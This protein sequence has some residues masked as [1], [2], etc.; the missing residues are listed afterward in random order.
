MPAQATTTIDGNQAAARVAYLCSELAAIYPITPSSPMGE[1]ADQWSNERQPNAWGT[2]PHV[3]EMQSEAGAA[4]AVH[5]ALQRGTLAT[6]FTASQGLLLMI[7]N[8][9]KIAGELT[10]TVFHVA[11]RTVATHALSIFC[12]H[13][14]VMATRATGFALLSS[15]SVQ[16]AMDLALV[17]H[18][19]TL[20][21][22]IPFLHFFDGFR[23]SHE[24]ATIEPVSAEDVRA[25]IDTELL[26]RHRE[27]ALSPDRPFIRGT[28]QN[29]DV[30]FQARESSNPYYDDCP[31]L[32]EEAMRRFADQ[33]GRQY[34]LFEYGGAPDA[35]RVIVIMG[36]AAQ[37]ATETARYLN[38]QGEKVGVV[39]VHLYRPFSIAHF[40]AV[41]PATTKT[42]AV[43]DRTKEPGAAGEPL[44]ADVV[45]AVH[46]GR[47]AGLVH[48]QP[49]IVGGRYGL[50]SKEFTPGMVKGIYDAMRN[51]HP[52]N[53]FTV[54]IVDDLTGSSIAYPGDLSIEPSPGT[55]AVFYGLGSDGTVSANKNSIMIIG[56]H[57]DNYAQGYFVYD[58]RKA[59]SVTVSHL[60]FGPTP[61]SAPYLIRQADFVGCHQFAF[62][63]RFDVLQHAR[64]GAMVLIDCPYPPEQVWEHLPR[65]VQ[66][67]I[68]K[69]RLRLY[70]IDA[71]TLAKEVGLGTRI[72]TIMQ[73][74]FF[75]LAGIVPAEEAVPLIKR[76]IAKAY[77]RRGK[78]VVDMNNEAVDRALEHLHEID[79]P[80]K[81][82]GELERE[83]PVPRDAP[84]FVRSINATMIVGKGDFL[85]VS[86]FEP[87]GTWPSATTQFEK[88]NIALEVPVW[89]PDIC[90]Q[91]GKCSLVCPHAVIRAK[92][93]DPAELADA[94]EGFQA[95]AAR[96]QAHEGTS[97]T[98]QVAVDHCTGCRLCVAVC[99]AKS[100]SDPRHKAINM[101]PKGPLHDRMAEHWRFF[102]AL[103]EPDRRSLRLEQ[104][105]DVQFL[106]PLFEFH[107]ACAGC[108]ETPYL[109]LLT[110]LLGDRLLIAN[111]TGCSSIYGGNLPTTPWAANTEGRGPAWCN[112]LFEDNGEF[113]LG[114]RL[115]LDKQREYARELLE[116][117]AADVGEELAAEII[118]A[119]QGGDDGVG[120]QRRRIA[121]LRQRLE[122]LTDERA[123]EL[124][125]L[126]D[127]LV[128]K[129]VWAVGGDGWAYDIGYGGLDHVFAL[130]RDM[131]VLVLDSEVYSNTGGQMSKATPLGAAAKFA[132]GGKGTPKKDLA[133]MAMTYGSVY[134]AQV[135]M[136]ANDAH[137]IKAFREAE[138]YPGTSMIIAYSH[139]IGQGFDLSEGMNHQRLAVASG[140][141]PLL[142]FDPRRRNRGENPLQ[143]DSG[144]PR[145]PL[146]DYIYTET[147]YRMLRYSRP[148]RAQRLLELARDM[149]NERW[150]LYSYL[151]A[152]SFEQVQHAFDQG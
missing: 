139:C 33:T 20:E 21:S 129:S 27:R 69:R 52:P 136:G 50:S 119:D 123:G 91:C 99:P 5:G 44:Y 24:V 111:A 18:T 124:A 59:G 15:S 89:D 51:A 102:R 81:A 137:T 109:K 40:G 61:I 142:R 71:Y 106:Q 84:P 114:M 87:D 104:V 128:R 108:G 112:S 28:S 30:F 95:I 9:Y 4:G 118:A 107:G 48:C 125:T 117:L 32:V 29:P 146:E 80:R 31:M 100:R 17:A 143:L 85:P 127:V 74:C 6:T 34:G 78:A 135:A 121:E 3:V 60:R 116:G 72:N 8:M 7:P 140:Y 130:G 76:F 41:L 133:L 64:Q 70:A 105:R 66:E 14:D 134:V 101:A 151:A 82:T 54:G 37:T 131:N 83:P 79:V 150:A 94:P 122:R 67:T 47:Q 25:L 93:C 113:G 38:E 147:R 97:F 39:T 49:M 86:A 58:S 144:P 23:T 11:A 62:L 1:L 149:V 53:H 68:V 148:D 77:G 145:V 57:T 46:E 73:T 43:L 98:I 35:E 12:D 2:V 90:I 120:E 103:P 22:R 16:Q 92:L 26:N 126:A 45:A 42:I 110:Q 88:R 152:R 141:W 75:A 10:P 65:P 36:S 132:A 115:A 13:S 56:E 63:H 138:A 55:R 19:A 96:S